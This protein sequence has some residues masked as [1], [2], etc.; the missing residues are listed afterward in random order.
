MTLSRDVGDSSDWANL[1]GA[2]TASDGQ[3]INELGG[4]TR[5]QIAD[6]TVEQAP[7]PVMRR[8]RSFI[9]QDTYVDDVEVD[10]DVDVDAE[11]RFGIDINDKAHKS[12]DDKKR[13]LSRV[14]HLQH[15]CESNRDLNPR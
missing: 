6:A 4:T 9:Q 3:A 12:T 10:V 11:F 1:T 15:T 14:Q 13:T 2:G 5:E 7:R 8:F